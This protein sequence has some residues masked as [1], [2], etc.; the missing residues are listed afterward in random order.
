MRR[1]NEAVD[2]LPVLREYCTRLITSIGTV[3]DNLFVRVLVVG[4]AVNLSLFA[5]G[6]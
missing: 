5:D 1:S 2:A 4:C 3:S 6:I